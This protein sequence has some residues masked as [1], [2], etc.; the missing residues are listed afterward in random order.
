MQECNL[1]MHATYSLVLYFMILTHVLKLGNWLMISR[2]CGGE[3]A[4]GP[5]ARAFGLFPAL[6]Y[7]SGT[8]LGCAEHIV[9]LGTRFVPIT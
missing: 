3:L 9:E 7:P 5:F 4:R 8:N 1:N 6:W 2:K